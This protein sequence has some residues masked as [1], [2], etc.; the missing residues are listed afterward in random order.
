MR[1]LAAGIGCRNQPVLPKLSLDRE[2]PGIHCGGL[3]VRLDGNVSAI[4]YESGILAAR[5]TAATRERIAAGIVNVWIQEWEW[6]LQR[7]DVSP[8]WSPLCGIGEV[9]S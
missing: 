7:E 9:P 2:V 3:R 6:S 4:R 5:I 8:G 1:G